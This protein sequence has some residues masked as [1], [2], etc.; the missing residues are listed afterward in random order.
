MSIYRVKVNK[1]TGTEFKE[2]SHRAVAFYNGLKR[3]TKRR[4]Y[5]RSS[6][7]RK[8]KVF[9]ALFWQHLYQKLNHRDKLRRLK[10]FPC[11]I[12][13]L[14]HTMIDPISKENP[15][16]KSELLHRFIGVTPKGELFVVQVKEDKKTAQKFLLSVFPQT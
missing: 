5:V 7:F 9:I 11:A 8:D 13:L 1:L 15:N 6:Y 16:K 3:I 10:F 12:D 14:R 4:P 2:V